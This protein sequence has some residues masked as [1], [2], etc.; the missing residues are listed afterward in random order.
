MLSTSSALRRSR[1]IRLA[2][3]VARG[4]RVP[5]SR[6]WLWLRS[7][8]LVALVRLGLSTV[9]LRRLQVLTARLGHGQFSAPLPMQN[10][11][12]NAARTVP[13]D[14]ADVAGSSAG[15]VEAGMTREERELNWAITRAA[16]FVPVA[17]CLTQAL[18]LQVMLGRR[19]LGS[20][21]CI[22][23]RKGKNKDFEAHAWV[24]RDGRVLIGGEPQPGERS[25]AQGMGRE[26]WTP[27]TAWDF[28][29]EPLQ[30][31]DSRPEGSERQGARGCGG[32]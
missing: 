3:L 8:P 5:A 9:P 7:L 2:R 31:R 24:E 23:V 13:S 12:Q 20:R 15:A 27:L 32:L 22:G 6:K 30:G 11:T 28:S 17:S 1:P 10:A 25:G 18:S 21:L 19:G 4:L 29:P 14:A 26:K 16:R